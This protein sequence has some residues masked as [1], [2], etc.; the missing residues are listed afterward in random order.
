MTLARLCCGAGQI[1]SYLVVNNENTIMFNWWVS[2]RI[3]YALHIRRC[4]F[5]VNKFSIAAY[6]S[7]LLYNIGNR[8]ALLCKLLRYNSR[9][10]L[11]NILF[12]KI[13]I[14]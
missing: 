12:I 5:D 9:F 13:Y 10:G 7:L 4:Y 3:K 8:S 11:N 1:E 2:I 6:W 14:F